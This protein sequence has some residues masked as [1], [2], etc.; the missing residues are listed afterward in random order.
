MSDAPACPAAALAR[1]S[2]AVTATY[3]TADERM[4]RLTAG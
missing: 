4:V 2:W 1:E 3:V